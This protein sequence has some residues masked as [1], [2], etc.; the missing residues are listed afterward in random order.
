M[1]S[2]DDCRR[3]LGDDA[4]E[5]DRDLAE[6]RDD[7]YRLARILAEI[8]KNSPPEPPENAEK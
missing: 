5:S 3:I 6:R 4:P 1:L 7:A 2:L 8:L